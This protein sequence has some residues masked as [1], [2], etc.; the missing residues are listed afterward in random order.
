MR[1]EARTFGGLESKGQVADRAP[2]VTVS[3]IPGTRPRGAASDAG[4]A[5]VAIVSP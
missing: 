5:G 2:D 1:D 4:L 3:Q